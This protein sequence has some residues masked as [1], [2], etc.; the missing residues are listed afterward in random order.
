MRAHPLG[1]ALLLGFAGL[2]APE[3]SAQAHWPQFR[4]ADAGRAAPF[5][6]PAEASLKD[7]LWGV[8]LPGS[9]HSS[10]VAWD[11]RVFVTCAAEEGHRRI[12]L[13]LDLASGKE[14]ARAEFS[15]EPYKTHRLNGFVSS[16][17]SLDAKGIYLAWN[18]GGR[19]IARALDHGLAKRWELDLGPT[20][21]SHG[22]GGS[23]MLL[24][25]T[26]VLA[27]D[28][29]AETSF[30]VGLEASSGKELWRRPRTS[31]RAAFSTPAVWTGPEGQ[32]G[33]L[34]GS[35]AHGLTCLNPANGE[36]L[37][38]AQG[39]LTQRVVASPIL[40]GQ[41]AVLTGGQG[42]G[43]TEFA[44]VA[45][46]GQA[47]AGEVR[48]AV[49]RNLP[50]VP[51]PV[52]GN[53]RLYLFSDG[54]IVSA[55]EASSGE[56]LWRERVDGEF[57]GSPILAGDRLYAMTKAGILLV[58]AAS[59]SYELIQSLDL[60]DPSFATPAVAGVANAVAVVLASRLPKI[61][62]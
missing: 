8:D 5:A 15:F 1:A 53:G 17:P 18:E 2:S 40:A 38:E 9:G 41:V 47:D 25:G 62:K 16:T 50:Y 58:L 10:P 32:R 30:L 28:S 49:R 19:L 59:D 11:R 22:W 29:E 55:L 23:G 33:V 60:G 7:A 31:Q 20:A 36:L 44:A 43:G 24:D 3:T 27:S 6:L 52:Y 35:T 48:Y 26:W 4:G 34:F 39:L 45:L 37:W 21:A 13:A 61:V 56:P 54:G 14:L 12:V 46:P 51:T 42:G 57:F